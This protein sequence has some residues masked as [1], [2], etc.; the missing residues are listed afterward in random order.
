[1]VESFS[2]TE[3]TPPSSRGEF[4]SHSWVQIPPPAPNLRFKPLGAFTV[5]VGLMILNFARAP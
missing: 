1:M 5:F 3:K 4:N 2:N